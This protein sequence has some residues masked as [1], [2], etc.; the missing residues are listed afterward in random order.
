MT[1]QPTEQPSDQP[2]DR[3][4]DIPGY[5]EVTLPIINEKNS[6]YEKDRILG[7]SAIIKIG[8]KSNLVGNT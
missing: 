1:C 4:T 5:M 7:V 2:P 6:H 8:F 3:Q